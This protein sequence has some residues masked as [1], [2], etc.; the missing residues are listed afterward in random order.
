MSP[1]QIALG[2]ME[3]L[4]AT[5]NEWAGDTEVKDAVVGVHAPAD[6]YWRFHATK[7][8]LEEQRVIETDVSTERMQVHGRM[9]LTMDGLHT[10]EIIRCSLGIEM[11][12]GTT[13]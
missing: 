5:T 13:Y 3:Y 10:L 2:I 4:S 9:K 11:H 8:V 7:G 6:L 1:S 12:S